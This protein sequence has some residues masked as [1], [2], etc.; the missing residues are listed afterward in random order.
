MV[1]QRRRR[2]RRRSRRTGSWVWG[3]PRAVEGCS[4]LDLPWRPT[5]SRARALAPYCTLPPSAVTVLPFRT[6]FLSSLAGRSSGSRRP[7]RHHRRSWPAVTVCVGLL[8]RSACPSSGPSLISDGGQ[9]QTSAAGTAAGTSCG[10]RRQSHRATADAV[11]LAREGPCEAAR[12][13]VV[14]EK[15][16]PVARAN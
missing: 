8:P 2:G 15:R 16:T 11:C 7:A 1:P 4:S 12:V 6:V 10:R 5:R 3:S 9:A 13:P 14:A